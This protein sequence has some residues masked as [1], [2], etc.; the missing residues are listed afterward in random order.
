MNRKT[1][2]ALLSVCSNCGLIVMKVVAG[3]FGGSVSIISEAIHS[4]MDLIAALIA[5]FAVRRS[6]LPPDANHPYGHSKIENISGV[7]E[8]LL[9]LG[10]AGWI[11]FEAVERLLDPQPVSAIGLGVVVMLISALINVLVSQHLY[12]VAREEE[13]V[14]L[15]ADALHL[16]VDVVTSVGVAAGL[17]LMLIA[18]YFGYNWY[19][20]D[21]IVAIGVALFITREGFDMLRNAFRPLLDHSISEQELTLTIETIRSVCGPGIDFYRLRTRY[22]GRSRHIDFHLTVPKQMCVERAH[23]KCDEI[24][25]AIMAV[26]PNAEVLIHVEPT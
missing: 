1:G 10:A 14:A 21:S 8:A 20:I 2:A 13:S 7:L 5:L 4:A 24:E 25:A 19:F 6:D 11:V 26:L 18:S 23:Q 15:E 16:K 17:G 9:I 22:A 12:R 3:I